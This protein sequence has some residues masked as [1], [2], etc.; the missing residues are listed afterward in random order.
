VTHGRIPATA[1]G[2]AWVH[3]EKIGY[4][5]IDIHGDGSASDFETR[6]SGIL[7]CNKVRR[8]KHPR[9]RPQEIEDSCQ[10]EVAELRRLRISRDIDRILWVRGPERSWHRYRILA[11]R[12]EEIAGAD[13][14]L[15]EDPG[16][17]V[18]VCGAAGENSGKRPEEPVSSSG[19]GRVNVSGT[20][21]GTRPD[22]P[23]HSAGHVSA[24]ASAPAIFPTV[25]G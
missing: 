7:A 15:A 1:I 13:Q 19:P 25:S 8:V 2:E 5:I 10:N 18:P 17:S 3:A 24:T 20:D 11:D 21:S 9:Y 12:L 14:A 23:V 22:E 6:K 16:I 4:D